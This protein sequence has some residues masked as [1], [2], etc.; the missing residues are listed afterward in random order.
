MTTPAHPNRPPSREPSISDATSDRWRGALSTGFVLLATAAGLFFIWQMAAS[1]LLIFAGVLFAAFFD[2]CAR[3]IK[4]VIPLSRGWRLALV[5]VILGALAALS[6]IWGAGHL[7]EQLRYL[8]R[9]IDAQL[10][11]LQNYLLNF[12]IELFGP[13][14]GRDFSSW[15][16][17]HSKLF[18]H[19]QTAVGTASSFLANTA[20]MLFLGMLFAFSPHLYRESIVLLVRPSYRAR[21][22][23]VLNEMGGVLQLWL[24]GQVARIV[25]M[26]I[27][28]WIVLYLMGLPGAFLLG[29]QAGLS[30]F[31]PYLGPI[32]AAIPIGL[33]AMPLGLSMLIWSVGVYTIVQSIEGYVIGPLILR[34]AVEIPPA[35]ILVAIVLFGSLFGVMGIA[36]AVP[37]VA[38]GRIAVLRFYVEDCLGDG[39]APAT[40]EIDPAQPVTIP[41]RS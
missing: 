4:P 6:I 41:G 40:K 13:E 7:P 16:P 14:G 1:L 33:V 20:I 28:V 27:C 23:D 36:L 8:V 9:V 19:A 34:Q 25:L 35:W 5:L 24:V 32:A 26:T 18:G 12:G 10:D 2:A 22:R 29:V 3:A 31:I 15:F 39:A 11:I 17:D 30:N 21:V 38:I 37:L